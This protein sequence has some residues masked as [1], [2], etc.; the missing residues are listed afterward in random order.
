MQSG[1]FSL[2]ANQYPLFY[3][4]L[5]KEKNVIPSPVYLLEHRELQG[6]GP[7]FLALGR[8]IFSVLFFT[9]LTGVWKKP[10]RRARLLSRGMPQRLSFKEP[11]PFA[12]FLLA[13]E[14]IPHGFKIPFPQSCGVFF[15]LFVFFIHLPYSL[16]RAQRD[17]HQM[18]STFSFFGMKHNNFLCLDEKGLSSA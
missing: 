13:T 17:S 5:R 2:P 11:I 9:A 1:I 10:R 6:L 8:R 7:G 4:C 3:L 14:E 15:F 12:A 16:I 18:H